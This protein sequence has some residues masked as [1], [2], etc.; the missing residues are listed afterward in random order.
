MTHRVRPAGSSPPPT[1]PRSAALVTGIAFA[2]VLMLSLG[3][4]APLTSFARGATGPGAPAAVRTS[5]VAPSTSGGVGTILETLVLANGS[6]LPGDLLGLASGFEAAGLTYDAADEKV[7]AVNSASDDPLDLNSTGPGLLAINGSTN[8]LAGAWTAGESPVATAYDAVNGDLYV[9]NDVSNNVTVLNGTSDQVL[10]SIAVG[11]GPSVIAVDPVNGDIYVAN[12]GS[13]N[14]TII[15]GANQTTVGSIATSAVALVFDP[16]ND[17]LYAASSLSDVAVINTTS[18]TIASSFSLG[19]GTTA[20]MTYDSADGD[21]YAVGTWLLSTT[22][23]AVSTANDSVVAQVPYAYAPAAITFDAGTGYLYVANDLD[24]IHLGGGLAGNV[25][26]L[27]GTTNA[28]VGGITV[29]QGPTAI[30]VDPLTGYVYI[31]NGP[32]ATISILVPAGLHLPNVLTAVGLSPLHVEL[33][34]GATQPFTASATCLL[35]L[36]PP[37]VNF[38]W[39]LSGAA[40]TLNTTSGALVTFTAGNATGSS[41]LWVNASLL[42][43]TLGA[44]A[45]INVSTT[46]L[47]TAVGLSPLD[48]QLAAGAT[49]PF[50]ANATCLLGLCPPGVN[51][52][53]GLAGKAGTLNTRSGPMVTFTAGD[54]TGASTLWVNASLLGIT[55]GAEATINVTATNVT[56]TLSG[57]SLSSASSVLGPGGTLNLTATPSCLAGICVGLV[58]YAWT[59]SSPTLGTLNASSGPAVEFTAGDLAA[60]GSV[61]VTASLAGIHVMAG[62]SVSVVVSAFSAS[63]AESV[64]VGEAPLAVTFTASGAGGV[65]PYAFTWAFGDGTNATGTQVEHTFTAAGT[66]VVDAAGSDAAGLETQATGLVEVLPAPV[67]GVNGSL[68]LAIAGSSISGVPP[69]DTHLN[70][71]ASGGVAP[72]TFQWNF[73]DGSASV[74]GADVTHDYA[75]A[76][77][78]VATVF[79]TDASGD[80]AETSVFISV[81]AGAAIPL[82]VSVTALSLHG[83]AP[84]RVELAPTVIGGSGSYSLT[85]SFGDGSSSVTE[86][87][88]TAVTHT[89]LVAGTYYPQLEVKDSS[90]AVVTWSASTLGHPVTAAAVIPNPHGNGPSANNDLL[91]AALVVLVA[92]IAIAAL[93]V[94]QRYRNRWPGAPSGPADG[95]ADYRTTVPTAL[96]GASAGGTVDGM[97]PDVHLHPT[98]TA[99]GAADEDPEADML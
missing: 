13:G 46:N 48:A 84:F 95:Y 31:A 53:W 87:N 42:G 79:V 35:G 56:G 81:G 40:G 26:V 66:Y 77:L 38:T 37:G 18:N 25:T 17:L 52:T 55:L 14:L 93:V 3:A 59:V 88:L 1:A 39:S 89:Y 9:A 62:A 47:L 82:T 23:Q 34:P 50:T 86:S 63:I 28:F 74:S 43:I 65:G 32:L 90:G 7:Y 57:V 15:D 20:G 12:S 6:L 98:A 97:I 58:T 69:L 85:W 60:N 67:A 27:N 5:S 94:P 49:Q 44:E 78:Y 92:A 24:N 45:I 73:G 41:T 91:I 36:C 8:A 71:S 54:V 68:S 11:T 51:Y 21:L 10:G 16:A 2:I 64:S 61:S 30:T 29:G 80:Q 75:T 33:A 96:A 99:S 19:L 83:T 22:I 76:G 72:Y 4:V 70:A